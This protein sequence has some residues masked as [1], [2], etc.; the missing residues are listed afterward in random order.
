M[1]KRLF[2]IVVSTMALILVAPIL[3]AV[4]V[5]IKLGSPGPVFSTGTH[6]AEWA[7]F[8]CTSL[9]PAMSHAR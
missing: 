9:V 3:G 6:R 1:S 7:R 5:A 2:G 4:A 8:I